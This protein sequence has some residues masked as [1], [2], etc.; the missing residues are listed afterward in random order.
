M[1]GVFR[2]LEPSD[3]SITPFQAYK[4]WNSLGDFSIYTASYGT[5]SSFNGGIFVD[6]FDLGNASIT[7][8]EPI[9]SGGYYQRVVWNSIDHIFY[10]DYYESPYRTFGNPNYGL[11]ERD[12]RQ[13]AQIVGISADK[14]GEGILKG[15]VQLTISGAHGVYNLYDDEYGNLK[16]A[17][18]DQYTSSLISY[19]D[20][21]THW[22]F[23]DLHKYADITS[24]GVTYTKGYFKGDF[25]Y[26]FNFTNVIPSEAPF[27]VAPSLNTS[28]A[29]YF[30]GSISSSIEITSLGQNNQLDYLNF[31]QKD[32]GV[33]FMVYASSDNRVATSSL[34]TKNG[35]Y[36]YLGYTPD[37]LT[38]EYSNTD[39]FKY[40][41]QIQMMSSS[42][43]FSI[44]ADRSNGGATVTVTSSALSANAW[45]HVLYTKSG[46][47]VKL[48]VDGTVQQTNTDATD[49][50][51]DLPINSSYVYL[52]SLG[53]DSNY[54]T[55]GLSEIL[56]IEK[57]PT[58]AQIAT[59]AALSGSNTTNVGNVFY[60]HG[61]I[62]ITD[63][64]YADYSVT[65]ARVRGTHTIYEHQ[66][67][68]TSPA[69]ESNFSMN[70]SLTEYDPITRS[71]KVRGMF[72][73]SY[74]NPYVTSI[75][76]Y[77]DAGNLL[78]AAK[79]P[80]PVEKL[81]NVDITY[82]IKFDR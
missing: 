60:E 71:K 42:A 12:L 51:P 79:L 3:I 29:A 58:T 16:I 53:G 6:T 21:L 27:I 9:T 45:H 78:V 82:V 32:F 20:K 65:A 15:S 7:G 13:K 17:A 33:S 31:R 37:G 24:G 10:R 81:D 56:F 18:N 38:Q 23:Y 73:E 36:R 19:D 41:Y 34:V 48:Y 40:P 39:R 62:V 59:L 49:T 30:T 26:T 66:V 35:R 28:S 75:G 67:I 25:P 57:T 54:F 74:F 8:S 11:Q 80:Q 47:T 55:G 4:E 44:Q 46:S 52:G 43:G 70:P 61:M 5:R 14:V 1:A 68:C 77:D 76:L 2:S 63:P 72:T 50:T 22:Q 64:K 69:G